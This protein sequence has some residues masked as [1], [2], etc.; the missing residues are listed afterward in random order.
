MEQENKKLDMSF[1]EIPKEVKDFIISQD[2]TEKIS[3]ICKDNIILEQNKDV[4]SGAVTA[5]L[6]GDL[7]I[8]DIKK[9]LV[10]FGISEINIATILEQIDVEFITEAQ[11]RVLKKAKQIID[12]SDI[13][14]GILDDFETPDIAP[15]EITSPL[16]PTS[17]F[18]LASKMAMPGVVAPIVSVGQKFV[19][20]NQTPTAPNAPRPAV[21]PYRE[22]PL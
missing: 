7:T 20:G 16:A 4:L 10:D 9:I 17:A 2:F 6:T 12:E 13:E 3:S 22:M 5:V 11:L 8:N 1:E 19:P 14:D 18:S 15:L 21:D